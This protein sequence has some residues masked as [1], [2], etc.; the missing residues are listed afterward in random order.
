MVR[1]N[2]LGIICLQSI[3]VTVSTNMDASTSGK[4]V[5]FNAAGKALVV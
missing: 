5:I 2:A 3:Q 4:I 1:Q